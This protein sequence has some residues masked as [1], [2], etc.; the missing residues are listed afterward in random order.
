MATRYGGRVK[1]WLIERGWTAV[2]FMVI[3][4]DPVIGDQAVLDPVT[5]EEMNVYTAAKLQRERTGEYPDF[6]PKGL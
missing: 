2:P 5:K 3:D 1:D 4:G 6:L